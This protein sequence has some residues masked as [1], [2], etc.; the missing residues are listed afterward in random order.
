MDEYTKAIVINGVILAF[1]VGISLFRRRLTFAQKRKWHPRLSIAVG[2]FF[3]G[4]IVALFANTQWSSH[5]QAAGTYIFLIGTVA[6]I[7]V[8]NITMTRWCE[9]CQEAVVNN[10]FFR[11]F[12]FCPKCGTK[13]I[14]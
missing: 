6:A 11:K 7:T 4:T 13:L 10:S 2:I 14:R 8:L 5:W 9:Q 3:A 12:E 1:A